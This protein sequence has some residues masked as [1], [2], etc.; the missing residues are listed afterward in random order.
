MYGKARGYFNGLDEGEV[1]A[2][3]WESDTNHRNMLI[4]ISRPELSLP[5][6]TRYKKFRSNRETNLGY[7]QE[8]EKSIFIERNKNNLP[9]IVNPLQAKTNKAYDL[10]RSRR[11][12][13]KNSL[14]CDL[15]HSKKSPLYDSVQS[16]V[17]PFLT[18]NF[19][20]LSS[21]NLKE[22]S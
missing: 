10:Y 21:Q 19:R 6:R 4:S 18:R 9:L 5:A 3:D 15:S 8:I 7:L 2:Y 1:I 13:E 14:S 16:K 22:S 11:I 17:K 12:R 20:N